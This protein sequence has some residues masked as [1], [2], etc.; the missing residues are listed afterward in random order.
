MS[1]QFRFLYSPLLASKYYEI[2]QHVMLSFAKESG[3][4]NVNFLIKNLE[5]LKKGDIFAL[6]PSNTSNSSNTS[7]GTLGVDS[8]NQ[9]ARISDVLKKNQIEC[10]L[11]KELLKDSKLFWNVY[12]QLK[13]NGVNPYLTFQMYLSDELQYLQK[14]IK[15]SSDPKVKLVRGAYLNYENKLYLN[16]TKL[17]T[18]Y[19]YRQAIRLLEDKKIP[20]I[21][22]TYNKQDLK[23]LNS[24]PDSKRF[25]F[26][27]L[28]PP[29]YKIDNHHKVYNYVLCGTLRD[30]LPFIRRQLPSFLKHR[31]KSLYN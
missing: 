2:N 23:F 13:H 20:T 9:I 17:Q 14:F 1:R 15:T 28:I 25:G 7:T 10:T 30:S 31:I 11:D 27:H 8:I 22:A 21:Y 5:T 26:L 12:N 4:C 16:K 18:D 3:N 24:F 29:F 19:N 6:K